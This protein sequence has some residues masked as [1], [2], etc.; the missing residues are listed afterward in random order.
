MARMINLQPPTVGFNCWNSRQ[1]L[2]PDHCNTYA[3]MICIMDTNWF[4]FCDQFAELHLEC[5]RR[6]TR[7][8]S[9]YAGHLKISRQQ[10]SLISS[11]IVHDYMKK[12]NAA[13]IILQRT[14]T[15]EHFHICIA[16]HKMIC[17]PRINW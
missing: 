2:A 12:N 15:D 5:H 10:R 8:N 9:F 13:M 11:F 14:V 6:Q 3:A 17:E 1:S 16:T 4:N 7:N